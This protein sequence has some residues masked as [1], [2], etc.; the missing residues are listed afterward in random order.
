MSV[1]DANATVGMALA[2]PSGMNANKAPVENQSK[3]YR[4]GYSD[5]LAWDLDGFAC[6]ED[7]QTETEGWDSA[8][9]NAVGRSKCA[10]KWGVSEE[11]PEWDQACHEYNRGAH[12]GACAPQEQRNG[13]PPSAKNSL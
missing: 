2:L 7:V 12:V 6:V 10:E 5:G 13:L 3:A 4:D 1:R 9:I 8:T 11:G